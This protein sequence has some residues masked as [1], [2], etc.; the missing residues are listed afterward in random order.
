MYFAMHINLFKTVC[1]K[2]TLHTVSACGGSLIT[3]CKLGKSHNKFVCD[4]VF[5][6]SLYCDSSYVYTGPFLNTFVPH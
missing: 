2:H 1:I 6:K 4:I 5:G 3:Y